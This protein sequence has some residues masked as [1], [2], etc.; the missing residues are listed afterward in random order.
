LNRKILIL[1]LAVAA[2]ASAVLFACPAE[3]MDPIQN[4][5]EPDE[6]PFDKN[7]HPDDGKGPGPSTMMGMQAPPGSDMGRPVPPEFID[8]EGNV[9]GE[10]QRMQT[11]KVEPRV[12]LPGQETPRYDHDGK[13]QDFEVCLEPMVDGDIRVFD[14]GFVADAIDF[15][16]DNGMH[17]VA[18]IL[19]AKLAA[20]IEY[21]M[22][23]S[24]NINSA[25]SRASGL[26]D[27]PEDDADIVIVEEEEEP[28]E[29]IVPFDEPAPDF[30][31]S[32]SAPAAP[33]L[34]LLSL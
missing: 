7:Q 21:N 24:S 13:P 10:K 29:A 23:S 33:H 1:A 30:Y 27:G 28:E 2:I 5:S 4:G 14:P 18:E 32:F 8:A 17:D 15:A 22:R 9:M 3:A 26:D 6:G 20:I 16:E 12:E 11:P 34:I 19:R 25:D 31:I